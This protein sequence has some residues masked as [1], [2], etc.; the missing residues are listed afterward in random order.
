M[1]WEDAPPT[2]HPPGW[3]PWELGCAPGTPEPVGIGCECASVKQAVS[4]EHI[5]QNISCGVLWRGSVTSDQEGEGDTKSMTT[6]LQ[7]SSRGQ[8]QSEHLTAAPVGGE[9]T[10]VVT[11]TEGER[12]PTLPSHSSMV[13][14]S[15]VPVV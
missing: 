1:A 4:T 9:V 6:Y 5:P 13:G 12:S 8:T 14:T 2:P 11:G 7:R 10:K 15:A 3:L